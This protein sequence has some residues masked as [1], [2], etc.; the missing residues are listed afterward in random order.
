MGVDVSCGVSRAAIAEYVGV[1]EVLERPPTEGE[2]GSARG[3]RKADE[4]EDEGDCELVF[5]VR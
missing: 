5:E 2:E 3:E 1:D 4:V